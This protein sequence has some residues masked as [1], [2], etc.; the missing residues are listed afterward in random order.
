[1]S[2]GPRP[3]AEGCR[4]PSRIQHAGTSPMSRSGSSPAQFS[5]S[6]SITA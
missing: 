4:T 3:S 5:V 1:M 2:R 6:V